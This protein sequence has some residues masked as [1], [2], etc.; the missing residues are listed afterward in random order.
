MLHQKSA[1]HSARQASPT[2]ANQLAPAALYCIKHWWFR[3]RCGFVANYTAFQA[4]HGR[5]SIC[6]PQSCIV[7]NDHFTLPTDSCDFHHHSTQQGCADDC[8]VDV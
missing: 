5:W 8:Y 4:Q 6:P 7:A 3:A 2:L 1:L